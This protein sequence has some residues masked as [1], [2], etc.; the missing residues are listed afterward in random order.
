M[1]LVHVQTTITTTFGVLDDDSNVIPQQPIQ[2]TVTRFAPDAFADAHQAIQ[3]ARDQALEGAQ[4]PPPPS[5][6]A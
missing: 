2:A 1:I 4:Q 6:K 3:D 5:L